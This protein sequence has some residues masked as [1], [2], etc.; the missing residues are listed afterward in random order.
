MAGINPTRAQVATAD[1]VRNCNFAI[2]LLDD[3]P[4]YAKKAA[5]YLLRVR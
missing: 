3:N 1:P 4:E 5:E 2:G